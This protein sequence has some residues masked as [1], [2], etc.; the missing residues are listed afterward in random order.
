MDRH[1]GLVNFP[2]FAPLNR[3]GFLAKN[4]NQHTY[5]P[6]YHE[7][8][9][10]YLKAHW[11]PGPLDIFITTHQKVG[12]HL[13]KK[14]VIELLRHTYGYPEGHGVA[15]GDI[16]HHTV[17]WPEVLVS[18]YGTENFESYLA[19]TEGWPR[20]WY[21][22]SYLDDLPFRSTHPDTKFVHVYRDPRGVVMSQ[23]HFYKSHPLLGVSN[24][25]DLD[26]FVHL[27]L[28][29]PLYFG[30][31]FDHTVDWLFSHRKGLNIQSWRY[32]DLVD[33]KRASAEQLQ[34]FLCP[35]EH[36]KPELLERVVQ[37]TAFDQ[38]KSE[39]TQKPQSFHF[40]TAKFFRA[41]TS[42]S[43]MTDLPPQHIENIE[44]VAREK[45]GHL[46]EIS[47]FKYSKNQP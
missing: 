43:W 47:F 15:T 25:L 20:V 8:R 23:Y 45:W 37:S 2:P 41:G 5:P 7:E 35:A 38:M 10:A 14:F 9:V 18:Q 12:T 46:P 39:L 33:E 21:L 3:F 6:F 31:Y 19:K 28:E 40:N 17:P 42:F 26:S 11:V 44:A 16:G 4:W 30:D 1:G 29:G 24:D 13:T 36:R 22:H 34:A 27:F 32:E